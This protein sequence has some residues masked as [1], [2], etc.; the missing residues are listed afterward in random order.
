MAVIHQITS[1]DVHRV[2]GSLVCRIIVGTA[3]IKRADEFTS[4]D[5]AEAADF[6]RKP[7]ADGFRSNH[8]TRCQTA[9]P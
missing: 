8:Y 6:K 1:F 4:H 9:Q 7:R 5:D 3:L 2:S